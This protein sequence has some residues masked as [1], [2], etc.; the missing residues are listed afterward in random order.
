MR[1]CVR[2]RVR[3]RARVRVMFRV[4]VRV[5]FPPRTLPLAAPFHHHLVDPSQVWQP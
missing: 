4:R 5:M 2:V 1:L 3:V